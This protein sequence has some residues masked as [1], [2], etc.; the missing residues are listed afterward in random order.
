M[1][2]Y[3]GQCWNNDAEDI[4]KPQLATC[5]D[6]K[7]DNADR[8]QDYTEEDWARVKAKA[9]DI[10]QK[11][12]M[13]MDKEANSPEIQKLIAELRQHIT[14]DVCDCTPEILKQLGNI[15]AFNKCFTNKVDN[16]RSGFAAFLRKA[17]YI[18]CAN[19]E[20]RKKPL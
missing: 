12:V 16:Y 2:N 15:Y 7:Q 5:W 19:A 3:S 11:L 14:E 8:T 1:A 20:D 18:Y 10:H 4:T 17:I 9:D 13:N 6:E